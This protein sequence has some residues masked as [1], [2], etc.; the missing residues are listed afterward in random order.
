MS[1]GHVTNTVALNGLDG[2][3][4]HLMGVGKFAGDANSDLLWVSD[5]GAARIWEVNGASV[6]EIPLN[7]PT[8]STLQLK[9]GT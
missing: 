8:G 2:L 7:V 1:N 4:W 5:S 3:E 6:T 9:P